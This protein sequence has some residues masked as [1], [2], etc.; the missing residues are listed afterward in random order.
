MANAPPSGGMARGLKDDLPDG[1]SEIFLKRGLDRANHVEIA[2]QNRVLAHAKAMREKSRAEAE[3]AFQCR[4]STA[5][6]AAG[7]VWPPE[8][9]GGS[10]DAR[11]RRR[12]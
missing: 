2:W 7:T 6:E 1:L 11:L 12:V 10:L 8:R 9:A 5:A 4:K 3:F